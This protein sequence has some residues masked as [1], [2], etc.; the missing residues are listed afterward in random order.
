MLR[1]LAGFLQRERVSWRTAYFFQVSH[2]TPFVA[3]RGILQRGEKLSVSPVAQPALSTGI[4]L[5][6]LPSRPQRA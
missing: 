4:L 2:D 5:S 3:M 1:Q 6:A